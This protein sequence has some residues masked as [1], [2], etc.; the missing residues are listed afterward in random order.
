[1]TSIDWEKRARELVPCCIHGSLNSIDGALQLGREMADARA[2]E[3]AK[4][5]DD[6]EDN[7]PGKVPPVGATERQPYFEGSRHAWRAAAS[8]ARST[9]SKPKT[10]EQVLEDALLKTA[11]TCN[12]SQRGASIG[13]VHLVDCPYEIKRRAL[14]WAP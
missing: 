1:M 7:I 11:V 3:I 4:Q 10:R 8:L 9:I 6:R 13:S 14:E 12:C 5:C 2:E